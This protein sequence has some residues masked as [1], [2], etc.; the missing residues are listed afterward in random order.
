[1]D[2]PAGQ[3]LHAAESAALSVADTLL[4]SEVRQ[5]CSLKRCG[6]DGVVFATVRARNGS[7]L[8]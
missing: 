7:W 4:A 1:M 2:G 6:A 5:R 8:D 3:E